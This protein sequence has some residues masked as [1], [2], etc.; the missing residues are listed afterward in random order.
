MKKLTLALALL[1]LATIACGS[2]ATTVPTAD[3]TIDP[4]IYCDAVS[5][6]FTVRD[7]D[8]PEE[9]LVLARR[10]LTYA[11]VEDI[12][13]NEFSPDSLGAALK[14]CINANWDWRSGHDV[15]TLDGLK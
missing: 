3:P 6:Q 10:P 15:T 1:I 5:F 2:S 8:D 7:E 4:G 12:L 9:Y 14:I 11:E 13:N